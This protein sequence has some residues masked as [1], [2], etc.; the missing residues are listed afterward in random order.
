MKV[1][2]LRESFVSRTL[3]RSSPPRDAP[4]DFAE[5]EDGSAKRE[6]QKGLASLT[7]LRKSAEA[8]AV[9]PA[10]DERRIRCRRD[11]T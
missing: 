4:R 3:T 1:F 10:A 9:N 7:K 2:Y 5:A 11:G 8:A 6:F